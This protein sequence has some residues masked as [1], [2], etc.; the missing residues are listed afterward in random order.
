ML[1]KELLNAYQDHLNKEIDICG[2]VNN[3]RVQ[4]NI[5]FISINDG[6][7]I[8]NLQVVTDFTKEDKDNNQ[9]FFSELQKGVSINIKGVVI[10]SIGNNQDIE[11][12]SNINQIN[13]IGTIDKDTY[14]IMKARVPLEYIRKYPEY[15]SRTNLGT[16]LARIRN[17]CTMAT[18]SFFQKNEFINIQT[19]ILTSN[20]CEG[21][22]ETFIV[23]SLN[24]K[25]FSNKVYLTVSGQL[26]L[27]T[28]SLGLNRVYTFGPTFR[29]ENSNTN[30]HL[31]EF[32]MVEPELCFT[33]FEELIQLGEDYIKYCI[34]YVLEN[35]IKDIEFIDKRVSNGKLTQLISYKDNPFKRMSYSDAINELQKLKEKV[36]WGD[37][38]STP[39]EKMLTKIYGPTIV[40][41]YPKK[42]KSFYMKESINDT[43]EAMDILMPEIGELIGGSMRED[44]YDKLKNNMEE[45]NIDSSLDWYLNLRKNGSVP[46]GGFGMGFERLIM[47]ITGLSNIKDCIHYPRFPD[48]CLK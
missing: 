15:K 29:A 5:I 19:P 30:R 2:W 35:N 38:L 10:N 36:N 4:T 24:N 20:D 3:C 23:N 43:V 42:I 32:W 46:H 18:H 47:L 27:E 37:D 39:Q 12:K 41:N 48:S 25:F 21:A 11:I 1:V 7:T 22:G 16:V 33:N 45:K 6:S 31:A 34:N 26:H 9:R 8:E 40:Y 17:S 44:N 14:P 13:I 28:V